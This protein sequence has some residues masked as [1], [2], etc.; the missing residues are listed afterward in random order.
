MIAGSA[1]TYVA[2]KSTGQGTDGGYDHKGTLLNCDV[3]APMEK[4][5]LGKARC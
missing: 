1:R 2:Q 4:E 5:N 3:S